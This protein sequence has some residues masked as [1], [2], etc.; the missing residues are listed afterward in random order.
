MRNPFKKSSLVFDAEIIEYK[1]QEPSWI[2]PP[3]EYA[4]LLAIPGRQSLFYIGGMNYDTVKEISEVS[5]SLNQKGHH[6]LK[7]SRVDYAC[8]D[9]I[10]PMMSHTAITF[11]ER[12]FMFAGCFMYNRKRQI[13]ESVSHVTVFDPHKTPS[14]TKVKTHSTFIIH[15]RK[16]HSAIFY[17]KEHF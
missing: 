9:K 1:I 4:T 10:E 3:R 8:Q 17:C 13:R 2:P 7:W 5:L 14:L 15:P 11:N 12:I 6:M 16:N